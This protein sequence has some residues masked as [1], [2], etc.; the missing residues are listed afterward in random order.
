MVYFVSFDVDSGEWTGGAYVLACATTDADAFVDGRNAGEVTVRFLEVYHLYCACRTVASTVAARDAVFDSDTVEAVVY[1]VTNV[2]ADLLSSRYLL[3]SA[4]RANLGATGALR[5]T[6]AFVEV[7]YRLHEMVWGCR[8]T[9]NIVRA[10][11]NTELTSS[12]VMCKVVYRHRARRCDR[13]CSLRHF[14][15][16]QSGKTTVEFL[17]SLAHCSGGSGK[18]HAEEEMTTTFALSHFALSFEL[19]FPSHFVRTVTF[20]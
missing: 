18:S 19:Y 1:S 15:L 13:S 3:N 11:G 4:C 6:E 9:Q 14:L 8:R 10:L 7:H 2:C 20:G 5:T 16:F 12:A 17:F